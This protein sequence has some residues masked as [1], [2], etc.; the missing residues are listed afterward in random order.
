MQL[1]WTSSSNTKEQSKALSCCVGPAFQSCCI[2]DEQQ[3]H[4]VGYQKSVKNSISNKDLG[5]K[6][7]IKIQKSSIRVLQFDSVMLGLFYTPRKWLQMR[8][9]DSFLYPI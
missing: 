9:Q 7:S 1:K 4:W 5:I 6:Q 8:Y 2:V 3:Y